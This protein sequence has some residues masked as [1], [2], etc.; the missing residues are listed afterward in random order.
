M[1]KNGKTQFKFTIDATENG[2]SEIYL[3]M[4]QLKLWLKP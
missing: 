2:D 1:L 4:L 3:E